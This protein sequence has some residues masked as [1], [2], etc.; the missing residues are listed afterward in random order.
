MK[1][2]AVILLANS[3][4]WVRMDNTSVSPLSVAAVLLAA[5]CGL[6][7]VISCLYALKHRADQAA[8]IRAST[9]CAQSG[10]LAFYIAVLIGA[11]ECAD[12]FADRA[13]DARDAAAFYLGIAQVFKMEVYLF[14]PPVLAAVA[15]LVLRGILK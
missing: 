7:V 13:C 6:V 4:L 10:T 15:S 3:E 14:L 9:L 11:L 12:L 2:G 1:C 8:A 5:A